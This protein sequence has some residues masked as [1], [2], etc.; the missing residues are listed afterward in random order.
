MARRKLGQHLS[1]ANKAPAQAWRQELTS[2]QQEYQAEYEQYKPVRDELW[3][4]K[5]VKRCTDTAL[6][7]QGRI[8][9]KRRTAER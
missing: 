1:P 5:Q 8:Q 4:L 6:H 7:K 9:E 2:L 3:K